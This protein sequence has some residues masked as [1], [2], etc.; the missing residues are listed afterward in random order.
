MSAAEKLWACIQKK[1]LGGHKF[2]R[3][4]AV[5]HYITD[6]ACV[7]RKIIVE[8]EGAPHGSSAQ[9]ACDT[10]RTQSLLAQGW[11]ILSYS[12]EDIYRSLDSVIDDIYAHLKGKNLQ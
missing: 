6:F 1:E 10:Q 2:I 11:T 9:L 8:L 7:P 12:N 3:Q 5:G 4:Y